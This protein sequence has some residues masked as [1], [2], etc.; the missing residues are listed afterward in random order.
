M[1]T[2]A[3]R[4]ASKID[5]TLDDVDNLAIKVQT[6]LDI[7]LDQIG[8]SEV[9]AVYV[10][11]RMVRTYTALEALFLDFSRYFENND[12]AGESWHAELLVRMME[13]GSG[14]R[15]RVIADDTFRLL[16]ELR[17]F[18][19]VTRHN[20]TVEYDWTQLDDRCTDYRKLIPLV[21]RDLTRFRAS[22]KRSSS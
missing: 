20:F 9:A 10:A 18:R 21:K 1:T 8:R 14:S 11:D 22:L 12:P 15:E 2:D 19:H 7:S 3:E 17:R 5:R 4:L 13:P 6:F 16:D